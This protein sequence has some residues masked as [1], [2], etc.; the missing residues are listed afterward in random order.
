[1]TDTRLTVITVGASVVAAIAAAVV[2]TTIDAPDTVTGSLIT[3]AGV[4]V[5]GLI[6]FLTRDS[7]PD[8]T[9]P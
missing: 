6:N 4:G 1:M 2:L 9:A 5:G 3:L 8:D 7:T